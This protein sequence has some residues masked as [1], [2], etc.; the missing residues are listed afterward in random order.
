MKFSSHLT[1]SVL[2]GCMSAFVATASFAKPLPQLS[3][4]LPP[5]ALK[6]VPEGKLKQALIGMPQAARDRA[7][8]RLSA[9]GIPAVDQR[10]MN[11]DNSGE[12]FYV[13]EG[14][15][16][17]AALASDESPA[18][19]MVLPDI[20][21]LKLHSNPL[22]DNTI[23]L[24]F[25]GGAFSGRAWGAGAYYDTQPFDLDGNPTSFND[26]ERARIHEIW[27][28]IAD[29]F[30]A[31]NVNVTT[32]A[33]DE[34]GPN[35]GWLLFTKDRDKNGNAMPSQGA[36]GVAYIGV[37][38]RSN[39]TYYQP[40]LVYYNQLGGGVAT[41]M[42]EAGS[43]EMGH[44]FGLAHDGTS[45]TSYFR[46]LGR[47]SDPSSWAPI[48]GVGYNKNV[49]QWSKGDYPDANQ[50]QDDI[51]IL[52][53]QLGASA[54][55]SGAI[56]SPVALVIDDD[57]NFSATNR[58]IDPG[59]VS[60]HNKGSIQV[61]DTDW[62]QFT[63]GT[64]TLSITATPAWHAFT[65]TGRRGSNLDIGLRLYDAQGTLLVESADSYE[66]STTLSTSVSEGLYV[67]EVYGSDGLYATDYGSQ[68]HYYLDGQ[69]TVSAADT[70]PPDP[71]PMQF[72]VEPYSSS[73][74]EIAMESVVATD[75]RGGVVS[76][77][78]SCT[79]GDVGCE[80]SE[81]QTET[82]FTASG[83]SPSSEYC[84]T[85][86]ARDLA[87]NVTEASAEMCTITQDLPPETTVPEAPG[88][89][90][91]T[92]G[93]DGTALLSWIDYSDD[94]TSFEIE[95]EKQFNV[96]R[97]RATT[98]VATLGE[99]TQAYVDASGKGT[100]RYRVRALNSAGSSDWTA[101]SDEVVV[102]NDNDNNNGLKPCRGNKCIF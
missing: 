67:L 81:W 37:W 49:T 70:M 14:L 30:A 46:G 89:L 13:E 68:G 40:A 93:Q 18:T 101:W 83:L 84:F 75:D 95:R 64:G 43:H 5:Q 85:V 39:Y 102:T 51:A 28:R 10:F 8:R 77:L 35:T 74:T 58:E 34:F 65:R 47:D 26:T 3:E 12:L 32:E 15:V 88:E 36:G 92:D 52:R 86:S 31:F 62:F 59:N 79:Y 41:Y 90:V 4:N 23:F 87:G 78:F 25:D 29:D 54:D 56:D 2:A 99:N 17:D 72:A 96:S 55:T 53:A 24:D 69:I 6:D 50:R 19:A 42:A 100:Y 61:A 21:V 57:G 20:D 45:T 38:G 33:P 98:I 1:L 66:T 27:T 63:A 82:A 11:A 76:Y 60:N 94:E 48:M 91:V 97:F 80:N 73:A 22:A 71:N 7:L 9:L 16:A 44:N